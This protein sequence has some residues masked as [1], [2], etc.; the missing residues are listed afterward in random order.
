MSKVTTK[1]QGGIGN[2]LFQIAAAYAYSK[3]NDKEFILSKENAIIVH[4]NIEHYK[5]N[6]LKNIKFSNF[7]KPHTQYDE[8]GFHYQDIPNYD[9]DVLLFGYFQSEKYFKYYEDDIRELF[10]SYEVELKNEIKNL[11]CLLVAL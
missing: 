3:K 11:L 5:D 10:M 2:M 9:S 4:K 1:L 7:I 6:I 8:N